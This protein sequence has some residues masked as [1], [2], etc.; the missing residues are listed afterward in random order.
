MV[1]AENI[2]NKMKTRFFD[3]I[4]S[5]FSS[6]EVCS[7]ENVAQ[8]WT[9]DLQNSQKNFFFNIEEGNSL[10]TQNMLYLVEATLRKKCQV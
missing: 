10:R 4:C 9:T 8:I 6:V 1:H 2:M 5:D 3:V 7:S